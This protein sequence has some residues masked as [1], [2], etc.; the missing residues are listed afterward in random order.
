MSPKGI[1]PLLGENMTSIEGLQGYRPV[2]SS[3]LDVTVPPYDVIKPQSKLEKVLSQNPNSLYHVTLGPEPKKAFERLLSHGLLMGDNEPAYYV[4]EQSWVGGQRRGFFGAVEVSPYAQRQII[5]HEKVFDEKVQGRLQLTNLLNVTL[6]PVFLLTRSPIGPVLASIAKAQKPVYQF[7]SDFG[8]SSELHGIENRIWRVAAHSPEGQKLQALVGQ[9]PL[10]IADGHHRYHAALLNHQTH[11]MAYIVENAVIQA[12]N[13]VI[14][15]KKKFAEIKGALKLEPAKTFGTPLHH[16]FCLYTK[17]GTFLLK[18]QKVPEDV[19][20]Q[21][22][23]SILERELYPVLG[24]SH[25][26][27]MNE[28]HFD[29][30]PEQDL[31]KMKKLVD[32]NAF[33]IAVALHPVSIDELLAVANAGIENPAI[34][35]PEKSTFFAPKILSGLFIYR[36]AKKN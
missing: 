13:R 24:L 12:Y 28:K 6:E 18:A 32:E 5:R 8:G 29:Y 26:L 20:G 35:M 9:N 25:D 27:I 3:V 7:S 17:Q 1:L 11:A 23:C 22:D 16:S 31:A 33:D 10:Y 15:G 30:F 2:P 14:N 34:V 21:L 4:Y 36:H 19:V